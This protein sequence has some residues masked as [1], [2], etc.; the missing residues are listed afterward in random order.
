MNPDLIWYASYGTNISPAR[1]RCYL[2]GGTPEGATLA[3]LGA[4]DPAPPRDV[5]PVELTGSVYFAWESASW[6]GGVAFY[7][8]TGHGRSY[9]AAYLLTRGQFSDVAAQEMHRDAADD[10]D[11][12]EL[13]N[14]G[15]AAYGPGRYETL[16][17][18]G[19]ID[20]SPVITFTS[21][22]GDGE[23]AYNPPAPAYLATMGRGLATTWGWD[24]EQVASYL[25]SRPGIG[26]DWDADS[27]AALLR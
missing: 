6:G 5:R 21:P 26:P 27:V 16:H 1:L 2:E 4:R 10:L 23:T 24:A 7:D 8:P 25:V 13:L 20:E 19:Q 12:A 22:T 9:G 17:V 11:L 15:R 3:C 14:D 18:V